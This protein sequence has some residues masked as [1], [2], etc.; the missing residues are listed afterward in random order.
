MDSGR[1]DVPQ[2]AAAEPAAVASAPVQYVD[3]EPAAGYNEGR[4]PASGYEVLQPARQAQKK[5]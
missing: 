2:A 3:P 5:K 1:I 4:E